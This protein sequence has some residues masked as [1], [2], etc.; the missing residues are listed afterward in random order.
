MREEFERMRRAA[1]AGE[2]GAVFVCDADRSS[3]HESELVA[4]LQE[5]D[6]HGVSVHSVRNQ[7]RVRAR[8]MSRFRQTLNALVRFVLSL[9]GHGN[10]N[11][12]R[13][14]A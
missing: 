5:L 13:D 14:R 2:V 7:H 3:R 11:T 1:A 9:V 10:S 6:G 8:V 12:A 4:P